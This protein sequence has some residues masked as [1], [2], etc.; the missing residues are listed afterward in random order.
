MLIAMRD[1]TNQ[2][3]SANSHNNNDLTMK[4]DDSKMIIPQSPL[5]TANGMSTT[6]A[7]VVATVT[8]KTVTPVKTD[9][10]STTATPSST[11]QLVK[12][13]DR[14]VGDVSM[15]VYKTWA[16]AAGGIL[17]TILMLTFFLLGEMISLSSNYWLSF[18]SQ[19]SKGSNHNGFS[20]GFYLG[21]YALLNVIIVLAS[22]GRE[23]YARLRGL[24]ASR[25]LFASLLTALLYAPLAFFETTPLGRIMNRCSKDI[26]T[27]DEQLP[28][29]LR[30]YLLTILRVILALAYI[31]F[32]TPWFM[33][34]LLPLGVFYYCAQRYYIKTSRELSRLESL[35]RSPIY[36]YF[37]ET[38]EGLTTIRAYRRERFKFQQI[39]QAVY[40]NQQANYLNFSAN[41][42]LAVRLEFVGT[43]ISS[44][45]L[46][47]TLG[48]CLYFPC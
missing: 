37:S 41:C 46:S 12:E 38:L 26:Y 34:L 18:W 4:G 1:T 36:N 23:Y 22:F 48:T 6:E 10:K 45:F 33:A 43:M 21:I 20:T 7:A 25:H 24:A 39:C 44:L 2:V 42:W 27:I 9:A 17:A 16:R 28:S 30:G 5:T 3:T 47:I 8:S 32:V 14:E 19:S 13:E 15:E 11:G 31:C 40:T 29:S 35:S